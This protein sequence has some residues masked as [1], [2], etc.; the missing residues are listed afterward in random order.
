M[1]K[2]L[3]SGPLLHKGEVLH[4][5]S[6]RLSVTP[7]VC[8]LTHSFRREGGSRNKLIKKEGESGASPVTQQ[9]SVHVLLR[10]PGVRWFRSW[11]RTCH[12]LASQLWQAS[13]R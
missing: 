13:H 4:F 7:L 1:C 12:H 11:V 3:A 9:L 5:P 6:W 8:F 10:R 2:R